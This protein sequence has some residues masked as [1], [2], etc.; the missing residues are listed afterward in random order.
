MPNINVRVPP[1]AQGSAAG[2]G[3][4]ALTKVKSFDVQE[5]AEGNVWAN[6]VGS[7]KRIGRKANKKRF[8]VSARLLHWAGNIELRHLCNKD[9][10]QNSL[11]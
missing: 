11:K 6:V 8:A 4:V 3:N 10:I 7:T 1:H 9:S 5:L 2:G